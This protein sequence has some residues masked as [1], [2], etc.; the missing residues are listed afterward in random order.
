MKLWGFEH[1][2]IEGIVVI[3]SLIILQ[4]SLSVDFSLLLQ[5]SIRSRMVTDYP[6]LHWVESIL[7]WDW[8]K[9]KHLITCLCSA[10]GKWFEEHHTSFLCY[11]F[12]ERQIY[13]NKIMS[14]EENKKL[15][16][17]FQTL[18]NTCN[19]QSYLQFRKNCEGTTAI[20]TNPKSR[21]RGFDG[22]LGLWVIDKFCS[23][24]LRSS[25]GHRK[26]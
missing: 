3:I 23:M 10:A 21:K 11:W 19:S 14:S 6:E 18:F 22:F 17:V 8:I 9:S 24:P 26:R 15:I 7:T 25:D 16:L 20:N 13:C 1:K 5:I 12:C 4:G 2:N